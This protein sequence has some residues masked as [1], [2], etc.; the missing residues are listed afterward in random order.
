MTSSVPD[1]LELEQEEQVETPRLERANAHD[2]N[3]LQE[4]TR[5]GP[6][7]ANRRSRGEGAAANAKARNWCFTVNNPTLSGEQLL[8][9]LEG[10]PRFRFCVFQLEQGESGTRH[11]Q[12]YVQFSQQERWQ[13]LNNWLISRS[14]N[15][16][17]TPANGTPD[18]NVVYCTK[19][20]TRVEGPWQSGEMSTMGKRTDLLAATS[21]LANGGTLQ[22]V[23]EQ[24]PA[25]FVRVASGLYKYARMLAP[26]AAMRLTHVSLYIG[27]TG[28]G[29]TFTAIEVLGSNVYI[30]DSTKWWE[31]YNGEKTVLWDD[32]AGAASHVSLTEALRLFDQYRMTVENKGGS[33]WLKAE[34]QVVTT[35]IHPWN[36][37]RWE[38]REAQ[39]PALARRFKL[40][41]IFSAIG[42][43]T[44]LTDPEMI[45]SF[46]EDP[47]RFGYE[48][49][50]PPSH[51]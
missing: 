13:T 5:A 30:K 32:F 16:Y 8:A 40:V 4:L 23:A 27:P 1:T 24:H 12:G 34:T 35:N 18:Q 33:E 28:T 7:R 3:G 51:Q 11:F 38:G 39:L 50:A 45:L 2:A 42:Q 48:K 31:C 46:F 10:H 36:W 41:R 21:I 37:Y 17:I 19:P 20:D 26:P 15:S 6:I 29:K 47:E 44:D 43:W 9:V 14:V 49:H 22:D 25:T